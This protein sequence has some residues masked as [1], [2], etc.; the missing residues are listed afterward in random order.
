MGSS[1]KDWGD[2]YTGTGDRG[3]NTRQQAALE[4]GGNRPS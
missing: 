2:L 3:W 1:I 4:H